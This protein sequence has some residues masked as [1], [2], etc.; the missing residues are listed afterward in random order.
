MNYMN[1]KLFKQR[2][3][4]DKLNK[5]GGIMASSQS[6]ME[7]VQKFNVGG[8]VQAPNLNQPARNVAVPPSYIQDFLG[9]GRTSQ[10]P[11]NTSWTYCTGYSKS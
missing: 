4:R 8:G 1:R 9:T 10:T 2:P 3:A 5:M 6:L 11:Q 7:S